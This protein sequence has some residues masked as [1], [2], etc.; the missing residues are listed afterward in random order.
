MNS[1]SEGPERFQFDA[2]LAVTARRPA[3][4]LDD[5]AEEVFKASAARAAGATAAELR[6]ISTITSRADLRS[7]ALNEWTDERPQ[8]S[9]IGPLP[10]RTTAKWADLDASEFARLRAHDKK[11]MALDA[12]EAN[13]RWVP[14]YASE[15]AQRSPLLAKAATAFNAN[16]DKEQQA[17]A[18]QLSVDARHTQQAVTQQLQLDA[19][20]L[21][22]LAELRA[23][24]SRN[25]AQAL[26]ADQPASEALARSAEA[27]AAT[28]RSRDEAVHAAAYATVARRRAED[29]RAAAEALGLQPAPAPG[30]SRPQDQPPPVAPEG[31]PRQTE[32]PART[33]A[34]HE[35]ALPS[36]DASVS[37]RAANDAG[38]V[39]KRPLLEEEV[40]AELR[41]RYIVASQRQGLIDRGPTEF[42][43]RGGERDG[44]LAFADAG[45]QLR[46][47]TEDKDVIRAMVT[48]AAAKGWREVT[49]SGTDDFR[50]AAWLEARL[51]G[52]KVHG[53]EPREADQ[54][55]LTELVA[56]RL[57]ANTISMAT[58]QQERVTDQ[59][60]VPEEALRARLALEVR[61][62]GL[63][64]DRAARGQAEQDMTTVR[65]MTHEQLKELAR[66]VDAPPGADVGRDGGRAMHERAVRAVLDR[67]AN[68]QAHPSQGTPTARR[69]AQRG[70]VQVDGDA[71]SPKE[72]KVIDG[73]GA[74]LK[75]R[76]HGVDFIE[77]TLAEV[78]NRMR[79]QRVHVGELLEHGVAPYRGDASKDPSYYV[80]LKT[81]VGLETVWGKQLGEAIQQ[82]AVKQGDQ[83]VLVNTGTRP[84]DVSEQALDKGGQSAVRRKTAALNEWAVRPIDRL[85]TLERADVA[86]QAGAEP[87]LQVYD[88]KAQRRAE[89]NPRA[90]GGR[91]LG[92]LAQRSDEQPRPQRPDVHRDHTR[93]P[94]FDRDGTPQR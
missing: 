71:L 75:H 77:A 36:A 24:Q 32:S 72:R 74:L 22:H 34:M 29:S 73:M 81:A 91:A 9:R 45:K 25:V 68:E 69:E 12:V 15:L 30:Q 3:T 26:A 11:D 61:N 63:G 57:P 56:D 79:R 65:A 54:R 66:W 86:R 38:V 8:A 23:E 94:P 31:Q 16:L 39:L 53:Y 80:T 46:T 76:G 48:V 14:D 89:P 87:A 1:I 35:P 78:E 20:A 10:P 85:S 60:A 19:Q 17:L 59:Q 40:P 82:G 41:R 37:P 7:A 64:T 13:V 2:K 84:V 49:L 70:G 6:K 18:R 4:A 67:A 21:A 88:P 47:V 33:H 28:A 42:T 92:R 55:R 52:L 62:T 83:V 51:E 93:R 58:P 50:R 43:F 90:Q 27:R 44:R 5:L